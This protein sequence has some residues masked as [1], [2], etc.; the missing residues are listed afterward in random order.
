MLE[1]GRQRCHA[2]STV[3]QW[4]VIK[5]QNNLDE[6]GQERPVG[7]TPWSCPALFSSVVDGLQQSVPPN[8]SQ[9]G[10]GTR[11]RP[12]WSGH[13]PDRWELGK[14]GLPGGVVRGVLGA[15]AQYFCI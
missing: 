14:T 15:P 2:R 12:T 13:V 9:R 6:A 8:N 3:P 7:P 4:A 10:T 11:A 1:P 5:T